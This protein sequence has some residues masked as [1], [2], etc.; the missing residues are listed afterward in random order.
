MYRT[1]SLKNL[2]TEENIGKERTLKY[3]ELVPLA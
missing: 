3:Y 1:E 2:G